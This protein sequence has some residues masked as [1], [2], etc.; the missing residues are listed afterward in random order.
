MALGKGGVHRIIGD[1]PKGAP[2]PGDLFTDVGNAIPGA[3]D[4]LINF[5]AT[6]YPYQSLMRHFY[7][8]IKVPQEG[9]SMFASTDNFLSWSAKIAVGAAIGLS[10]RYAYKNS[11]AVRA[12]VKLPFKAVGLGVKLTAQA[13]V[14]VGHGIHYAGRVTVGRILS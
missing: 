14:G 9:S 4:S 3:V 7:A 8:P 6:S 12:L 5:I 1:T 10:A 13:V 2:S 11:S